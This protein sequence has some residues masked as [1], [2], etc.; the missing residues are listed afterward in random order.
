[1]RGRSAAGARGRLASSRRRRQ[2]TQVDV[3]RT[4]A[5]RAGRTQVRVRGTSRAKHVWEKRPARMR[6][7]ARRALFNVDELDSVDALGRRVFG[8]ATVVFLWVTMRGPKTHAPKRTRH[9]P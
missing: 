2:R 6:R 5:T 8:V 1:L 3:A 4:R 9:N 7:A